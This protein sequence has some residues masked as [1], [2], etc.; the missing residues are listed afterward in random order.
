VGKPEFNMKTACF[1]WRKK[2]TG[3]PIGQPN[4]NLLGL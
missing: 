1:T 4:I 3:E 2:P